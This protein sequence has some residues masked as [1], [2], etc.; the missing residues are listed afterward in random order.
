MPALACVP[1]LVWCTQARRVR[2]SCHRI[3]QQD[4][5]DGAAP[6]NRAGP[7]L[8]R[9]RGFINLGRSDNNFLFTDK[10]WTTNTISVGTQHKNWTTNTISVGTQH[11]NWTTN[12]I[13]VRTQHKNWATNTI[14]VGTQHK[15]LDYK[16]YISRHA[17]LKNGI[18]HN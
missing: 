12:T 18:C 7:S 3:Q 11:K 16:Y 9:H 14:S 8:R 6:R 2:R 13:S 15:K 17:T 5:P 1:A 4:A 10:N